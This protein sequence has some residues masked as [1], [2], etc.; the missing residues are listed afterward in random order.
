MIKNVCYICIFPLD[1]KNRI[2][3]AERRLLRTINHLNKE[4]FKVNVITN[5]P[6]IEYLEEICNDKIFFNYLYIKDSNKFV[7]LYNL[8]KIFSKINCSYIHIINTTFSSF[9]ILNLA[10]FFKFEI[11]LSIVN[12]PTVLKKNKYINNI[13]TSYCLKKSSKIDWLYSYYK[14]YW[15]NKDIL[16]KSSYTSNS[17]TDYSK[18]YSNFKEKENIIL[19]SGRFIDLKQPL[20]LIEAISRIQDFIRENKYKVLMLG[21]GNLKNNI[22]ESIIKKKIDDIVDLNNVIEPSIYFNKSKIFISIQKHENYPS[23]SLLEA[24]ASLNLVIA[25]DVGDTRRL[26]NDNNSILI[27][28]IEDLSNAIKKAVENYSFY[29]KKLIHLRNEIIKIHNLENSKNYFKKFYE[30]S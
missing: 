4:G 1:N 25:T 27:E 7:L 14:K 6:S 28:N 22:L 17:F 15:N 23:Q 30:I 16:K 18:F 11:L 24:I 8:I 19:F 21:D 9:I 12:Y 29:N 3:G 5:A 26:I 13:I 10:L 2:G 20:I